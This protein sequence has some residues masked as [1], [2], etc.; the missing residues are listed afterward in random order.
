MKAI[1]RYAGTVAAIWLGA[2]MGTSSMA[3]AETVFNRGNGGEPSTL[4]PHYTDGRIESNIFRDL[5]EGLVVYGPDGRS[6]PGVAESWDVSADGLT[7]TF[8]L[9]ANAKWSNGDPMT[10]EDFVY[11]LRRALAPHSGPS[12]ANLRMIENADAVMSGSATPDKLGVKA[13]DPATVRIVLSI[14]A[15]VRISTASPQLHF[16]CWIA[17]LLPPRPYACSGYP[18]EFSRNS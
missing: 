2:A 6:R 4:D 18:L 13:L 1:V 9:R 12:A 11:S 8:H 15:P 16:D 14:S 5:F 10:A 17:K 3:A 7:Y